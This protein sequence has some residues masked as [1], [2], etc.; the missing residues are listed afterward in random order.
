MTVTMTA[1]QVDPG[2]MPSPPDPEVSERPSAASLHR[3]LQ[4]GHPAR[5]G[6][7]HRGGSDRRRSAPRAAVFHP[8]GRLAPPARDRRPRRPGPAQRGP[9]A[10]E[11]NP[12]AAELDRRGGKTRGSN[13]PGARRGDHRPP[14]K[15]LRSAG[16]PARLRSD[17]RAERDPDGRRRSP[18]RPTSAPP[19]LRRPGDLPRASVPPPA[20]PPDPA[21]AEPAPRPRPPR[22]LD[23]R[24]TADRPR[25]CC[26]SRASSTSR[27]PRSTPPCSTR[28]STSPRSGPCTASWPGRRPASAATSCA[29]RAMPSRSCWRPAQP[30][31]E[32]GHHQAAGSGEVDLLLPL[33]HPR[34]LQPL[35]G[36]LDWSPTPRAP[37]W[38]SG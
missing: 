31:V 3:R 28:A 9:K 16:D 32:L 36:R 38:P 29:T 4:A 23:G 18:R 5:G 22:A 13:A 14:V 35:R 2:S 24:R 26:T 1:P 21:A 17:E 15:T 33:R 11:P 7:M 10:R 6:R 25:P 37:P 30:G 19:R 27:R 8:P 34:H 12:L 20:P